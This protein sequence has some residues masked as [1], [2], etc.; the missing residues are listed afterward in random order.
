MSNGNKLL[1]HLFVNLHNYIWPNDSK[2]MVESLTTNNNILKFIQYTF[3][4]KANFI[5]TYEEYVS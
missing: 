1:A 2:R 5:M 4:E 3:N